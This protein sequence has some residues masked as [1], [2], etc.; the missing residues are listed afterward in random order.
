MWSWDSYTIPLLEI[1]NITDKFHS[2]SSVITIKQKVK[3]YK[4]FAWLYV[5]LHSTQELFS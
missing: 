4:T 2:D 3:L 1:T 5:I